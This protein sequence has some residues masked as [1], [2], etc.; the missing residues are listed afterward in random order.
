MKP[1]VYKCHY[2]MEIHS[3]TPWHVERG[4][5]LDPYSSWFEAM[6]YAHELAAVGRGKEER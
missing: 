4:D 1:R 3:F 6:T 5:Y 2:C